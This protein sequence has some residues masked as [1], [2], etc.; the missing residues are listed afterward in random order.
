MK[1][2]KFALSALVLALSV[3]AVH[4]AGKQGYAS[5]RAACLAQAGTNEREFR[6]AAQASNQ[7]RST[8]SA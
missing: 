8:S 6:S 1:K 4:A 2:S 5:A 7:A 3:P